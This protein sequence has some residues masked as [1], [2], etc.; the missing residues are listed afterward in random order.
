MSSQDFE[1]SKPS[2]GYELRESALGA[3]DSHGSFPVVTPE[4]NQYI[5]QPTAINDLPSGEFTKISGNVYNLNVAGIMAR[6]IIS[7]DLSD[8]STNLISIITPEEIDSDL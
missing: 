5:C 2:K 1:I 3:M 7:A 6:F 8:K 4:E